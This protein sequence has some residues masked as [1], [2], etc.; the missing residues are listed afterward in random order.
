MKATRCESL[1]SPVNITV[2]TP[3]VEAVD[4]ARL[5]GEL[6]QNAVTKVKHAAVVTFGAHNELRVVQFAH[7]FMLSRFQ[8]RIRVLFTLNGHQYDLLVAPDR[9]LQELAVAEAI[10]K[11][12]AAHLTMALLDKW[13]GR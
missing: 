4:A 9:E 10:A 11:H 5:Y 8:D 3:P 13:R 2:N 6:E 12:L 7:E 1:T